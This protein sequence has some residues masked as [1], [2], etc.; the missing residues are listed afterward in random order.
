MRKGSIKRWIASASII[1]MLVSNLGSDMSAMSI[2]H[3]TELNDPT[4]EAP[5]ETPAEE[6]AVAE[7]PAT[8]EPAVAEEPATE[9]PA[10]AEEPATAD[11][12]AA[13]Q[14][15]T[16]AAGTAQATESMKDSD[17]AGT[18]ASN[19]SVS[20]ASTTSSDA[21]STTSSD[22]A[23]TAQ[24]TQNATGIITVSYTAGEGGTVSL[25]EEKVDLTSETVTYQGSTA[26]AADGYKFINWTDET[27][28]IVSQDAT[29]VPGNLTTDKAFVANFEKDEVAE[30][31]MVTVTYTASEGGTV[32][33]DQEV[34]DLAGQD[35]S[36]KGSTAT[37]KEGY[38]FVSWNDADG[39]AVSKDATFVPEI[40][41]KDDGTYSEDPYVYI[42][43]FDKIPTSEEI[44]GSGSY[45][46]VTVDVDAPEGAF[47]IGTTL[48]INPVKSSE[49]EN[50][51]EDAM[52]DGKNLTG[53][54]AFDITFRSSNGEE[55]DPAD[56]YSVAVSFSISTVSSIINDNTDELQVYHM[57]DSDSAAEPIGSSNSAD[58]DVTN[59]IGVEADHFSIYVVSASGTPQIVTY[60][61]HNATASTDPV[62]T[63]M[64]KN[65]D[66]LIEPEATDADGKYF[67][68]WYHK[69][70]NTWG[71][72]FTSFGVQNEITQNETV[73]LYAKYLD[74]YY[75][76]FWNAEGTTVMHTEV[77][78]DH[79][80]HD[81]SAVKYDVSSTQA[82]TGW[83]S[84]QGGTVDVSKNVTVAQGN[85]RLNLY[86]IVKT[87][88]W[89]TFHS[90][91]GSPVEPIF[92]ITGATTVISAKPTRIGYTFAG[93]Y[94]TDTGTGTAVTSVTL[95][96]ELYA[97]WV[98]NQASYKIVYW[99]ENA[100]DSNYTYENSGTGTGTVE[101]KV[102]LTSA[103]ISTN[104]ID[105]SYSK[106]FSYKSYDQNEIIAGDGSTVVNVYFERKEYTIN[107]IF[108]DQGKIYIGTKLVTYFQS[109]QIVIGVNEYSTTYSFTAK[110][111]SNIS[112]KWP[113]AENVTSNPTIREGGK[114]S[115]YYLE[116]FKGNN[117][118]MKSKRLVLTAD[119]IGGDTTTYKASWESGLVA[120]TLHYMLQ[121]NSGS[122][123]H[124]DY[125]DS[126]KY[127]QTM[128]EAPETDWNAKDIEGFSKEADIIRAGDNVYFYYTRKQYNISFDT[129][130]GTPSVPKVNNVY[131]EAGISG[132]KPAAYVESNTT[133]TVDGKTYVFS[134]WYDNADCQGTAFTF[135]D[136]IM[137]AHD[138]MLYAKWVPVTYTVTFV[139]GNGLGNTM[140]V[141]ASGNVVDEPINPVRSGYT[142][143][144][145]LRDGKVFN[146]S[147]VITAATTLTAK[148][149]KNGRF[150]V[151]Y[152][153]NGGTGT[154]TDNTSYADGV[155]ATVKTRAGM[156]APTG[157]TNF[158][159][160]NTDP[161]GVGTMYQPGASIAINAANVSLYAI[162]GA[163]AA[164]TTLTY[165]ANGG[166]GA[167]VVEN[168]ANNENAKVKSIS[169]V[170]FTV[171]DDQS[172]VTWNDKQDGTGNNY[173][174]GATI[175]VDIN[176]PTN[177]TLY[178]QWKPNVHKVTYNWGTNVPAGQNLPE[179]LGTYTNGQSYTVE[180]H[181]T[182]GFIVEDINGKGYWTFSGWKLNGVKVEGDRTIGK[183]DVTLVGEWAYCLKTELT[184]QAKSL[185]VF[186]N[187][188][189]QSLSGFENESANGIAVSDND[190]ILYVSGLTSFAHAQNITSGIDTTIS[191]NIKI[192]LGNKDVT[193]Q[194]KVIVKAGK[195][196]IN[197][198]PV[199]VTALP[200][201]KVYGAADPVFIANVEGMVEGESLSL[202][203]YSISR[204]P[205]EAAMVYSKGII[206]AG[207]PLQGNYAVTYV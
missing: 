113:T 145:W 36:F 81:F 15:Q 28:Q 100:D 82:V 150:K 16:D 64:V 184:V 114:I 115:T 198:A 200:A 27:E 193:N 56:G 77:V 89:V 95:A 162:W 67:A 98:P 37:A 132:Y 206:P 149:I 50:A 69:S 84:T 97:K 102:V 14:L 118:S 94:T 207:D 179:D 159:G 183:D 99:I 126:P 204:S 189:D 74:G 52:D 105:G 112:D 188:L 45:N 90:Q 66:L 170:N 157:R 47:P 26:T 141:V 169:D 8:E 125:I 6:P 154:V 107:F 131:F 19:T 78:T 11:I 63:Q 38:E 130:G 13:E 55:L 144:G 68:G 80:V 139:Y 43:K 58:P 33:L 138:L 71:S 123:N 116:T 32:S 124:T 83:A 181:F 108:S 156:T 171:P 195:L 18:D 202:I 57:Q 186:Y 73:D 167:N 122:K 178:A 152:N 96:T 42:A 34:V 20:A 194:Y 53:T 104:H 72:E 163:D 196:I 129:N 168:Y 7:E 76:Y 21:A 48:S 1:A 191:G 2:V 185:T 22:A 85:T 88:Y 153:A 31:K 110:Y 173:A 70:G 190:S 103:Q 61:F 109:P 165:N 5:A 164:K 4:V 60:K 49:V 182:E 10:V 54:V 203:N 91:N 158:L 29:F 175:Y 155:V 111:E 135:T 136:A 174:I 25:S 75:V 17:A 177:N 41:A 192:M 172:F 143:A 137:P 127:L 117:Q 9:E 59:H 120:V 30:Q 147:T 23:S 51:V 140:Q 87:G 128:Q 180:S 24:S 205:G 133:K 187:G 197:P 39:N 65:G 146:F 119:L 93:W 40:K 101:Q 142:F 3:A 151:I 62:D 199:T 35:S 106:Y 92:A 12:P 46:G 160:W 86:A 148:W 134:G 44:T 121:P 166:G 79:D 161:N 201:G 176:Q